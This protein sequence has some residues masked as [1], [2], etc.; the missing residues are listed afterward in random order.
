VQIF[1]DF[2]NYYR[3]FIE[4]YA[5]RTKP[6]TNLLIK[7]RNRRKIDEFNWSDQANETFKML[8]KYFQRV[9]ILRIFDLKLFIRI[10]SDTSEFALE[11]IL[12]QLFS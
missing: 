9:P 3:R 1:L 6:I 8:K 7:M 11:K 12:F 10:K 4:S 5:R 2:T